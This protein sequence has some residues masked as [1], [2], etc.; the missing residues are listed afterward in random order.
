MQNYNK[1][2]QKYGLDVQD[3]LVENIGKNQA[4]AE[5]SNQNIDDII[6]ELDFDSPATPLQVP[7]WSEK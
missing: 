7:P 1:M 3:F 2:L 5:E 4:G 6:D